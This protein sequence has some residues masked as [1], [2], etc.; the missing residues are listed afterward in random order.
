MHWI[1]DGYRYLVD[2]RSEFN[3][4]TWPGRK[5][6]VGGTIG[7]VVI[8]AFLTLVLWMMDFAL[9]QVMDLLLG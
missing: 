1:S 5:E 3:K 9:T 8:V 6:Y 7:V 2:V 4:V